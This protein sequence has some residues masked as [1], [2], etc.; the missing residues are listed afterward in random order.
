MTYWS[1]WEEFFWHFSL[2]K[3]TNIAEISAS[4][5]EISTNFESIESIKMQLSKNSEKITILFDH[6]LFYQSVISDIC[7][8]TG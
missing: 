2:E 5:L 6:P 1:Q 4:I 3:S 8:K 7:K